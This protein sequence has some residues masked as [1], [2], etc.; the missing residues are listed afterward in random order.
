MRAAHRHLALLVVLGPAAIAA[1]QPNLETFLQKLNSE[2]TALRN[3]TRSEVVDVGASAVAP[4][5]AII[6]DTDPAADRRRREVALV[7]RAALER[8]V[9]HA[10]RSDSGAL[11]AEVGAALA[12][13]LTGAKSAKAKRE[14]AHLVAFIG[15]DAE[16]PAVAKLLDDP[17]RH[18]RETARLALERMP[19]N[20]A[21]EALIAGARN[22]D[23]DRK[24]DLL[25]SL[26]RK[27]SAAPFL[28][29]VARSSDG[30]VRLAAF[31]ALAHLAHPAAGPEFEKLL[32]DA[33]LADRP[34][35]FL[36]YLR[37]ADGTAANVRPGEAAPETALGAYLFVLRASP[38]DHHRERA[39]GNA[40]MGGPR[41]LDALLA[42]LADPSDRVRRLA[43]SRFLALDDP[44]A[45]RALRKAYDDAGPEA[46][47]SLL[48][49]LAEKDGEAAAPLVREA[50]GTGD[51]DLRITALDILG[52]LDR[53]DME[54]AYL[55]AAR[56]G[57]SVVRE[58]ALKGWLLRARKRLDA[59]E[60]E[61]AHSMFASALEVA[62]APARRSEALAGLV[63]AGDTKA[64]D[65]V[66]GLVKDPVLGAEASKLLVDLAAR[67]GDQGDKDRAERVLTGVVQGEFPP[68]MK[69]RALEEL[70]KLGRD[71]QEILRGQGYI[72]NWWLIGPMADRDGKGLEEVYFPE[73]VIDLE[74]EQRIGPRRFRWKKPGVISLDGRIQLVPEFRRSDRM[75]AYAYAEVFA[76]EAREVVF[77]MGSDDGIA[78]F[79][80][81]KRVHMKKG[82]RSLAPDQDSIPVKL[83]KGKNEVLLKVSNESGE[84]GFAFR[85]TDPSGKPY[86]PAA[87]QRDL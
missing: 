34:Q 23:A 22:A 68:A 72:V 62:T 43:L 50:S 4:L 44:G 54:D 3:A 33:S 79:L 14:V 20:A 49:A 7:A 39:L 58:P 65:A 10:G 28:L 24:P 25:F 38:V 36:E 63:A 52:D 55:K 1:E 78:C 85:I 59:G 41:A 32:G 40:A 45:A 60:K 31:Q 46:R 76:P 9:H 47:P 80:N 15:S 19:G 6:D 82:P 35:L 51:P 83:E 74:N 53:A 69:T 56:S 75:I 66:A 17:D 26:S 29:E 48:R 11:R 77:K 57:R 87:P 8:L 12:K 27:P 2:E 86:T 71:P 70:R 81:K 16:T 67:L 64:I 37:W 73:E 42:G 5:V 18:V 61:K 84:W 21:A 30:K 13:A